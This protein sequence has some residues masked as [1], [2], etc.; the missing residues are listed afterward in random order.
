MNIISLSYHRV[1]SEGEWQE[2]AFVV[3]ESVFR[4]QME[5]L[6]R[7]GY[8]TPPLS[9]ALAG[10]IQTPN[11]K[12]R[13][14]VITFDDGYLD[15]LEVVTP[16]LKDFGFTAVWHFVADFSKEKNW[17]DEDMPMLQVTLAQRRHI[18]NLVDQGFEVGS[19]CLTHR[20]LPTLN[21]ADLAHELRESKRVLEELLQRPVYSLAYPFGYLDERVKRAARDSGYTCAFS[22]T[23]G[24][25]NF[26]ADLFQIR[27]FIIGNSSSYAY[28][29]RKLEGPESALRWWQYF[30][31]GRR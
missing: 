31:A 11:A 12:K 25:R 4:Q 23:N 16:I 14:V 8:Y 18:V 13:P 3:R 9:Q 10:E 1:C 27:R 22:G 15:T 28:M 2:S 17:W 24:P 26:Y 5:Y 20:S 30:W 21:D 7:H 6:A 29:Y 19:H